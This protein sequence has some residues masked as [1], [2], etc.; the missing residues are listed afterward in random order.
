MSA[1][2]AIGGGKWLTA[3]AQYIQN[4][5]HG[6]IVFS[7]VKITLEQYSI[8]FSK[9]FSKKCNLFYLCIIDSIYFSAGILFLNPPSFKHFLIV[10]LLKLISRFCWTDVDGIKWLF[11]A[12]YTI[13]LSSW[14]D[15]FLGL[16]LQLSLSVDLPNPSCQ[17]QLF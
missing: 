3:D 17:V 13:I 1:M 6:L 2:T 11:S 16:P 12:I 9:M 5:F 4:T 7:S 10:I 14:M 15:V 8:S